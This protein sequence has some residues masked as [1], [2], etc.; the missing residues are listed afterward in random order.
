VLVRG[1]RCALLGRVTMDLIMIDVSHLAAAAAGD[2]VVRMGRL[3]GRGNL[4]CRIGGNARRQ[5]PGKLRRELARAC[6]GFIFETR[7]LVLIRL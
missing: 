4:L 3:G 2:E 6:D 5:L 7:C 1:Q